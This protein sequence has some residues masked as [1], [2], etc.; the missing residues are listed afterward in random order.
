MP[1]ELFR[2]LAAV[3]RIVKDHSIKGV[4]GPL[5]ELMECD[6]RFFA[7]VEAAATNQLFHVVVDDDAVASKIIEY[8]NKDRAGRVTFLPLN[9]LKTRNREYPD[10]QDVFPMLS[11]IRHDEKIRPALDKVFGNVLICRNLDVA[12]KFAGSTNLDCVTMDGDCVSNRGAISG[13]YQDS[14]RSRM[15]N[16]RMLREAQKVRAELRKESTRLR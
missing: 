11:K 12:V 4:H 5:I 2:G 7:A 15:V 9:R 3:Q 14:G 1:R 16:M 10:S 13:G 6:E 8:L